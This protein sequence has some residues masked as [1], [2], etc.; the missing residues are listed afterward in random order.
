MIWLTWRQA[1]TQAWVALAALAAV[2]IVLLVTGFQ[3]AHLYDT[4]GV[5]TCTDNC[6]TL[7]NNFQTDFGGS[8]YDPIFNIGVG[9][10]FVVPAIVGIF[11]GAPLIAR[12]LESGTYRLVWNQ[13]VTRTRWL[14]VKLA[15][16]GLAS[17]AFVGLLSLALTWWAAPIDRVGANRLAPHIFAARGVVPL[18]YAAF[19]F[20][21]GVVV[22]MLVRRVVPAMAVTLVVVAAA[23][24]LMPMVVRAH[25]M[26]PVH[27]TVALDIDNLREFSMREGGRMT[28]TGTFQ[29]PGAW[30]LSNETITPSG[31]AFVGPADPQACSRD[32]APQK[33]MDWVVS[34]HLRQYVTYQP[35]SRFW[36]LQFIETGLFLGLAALLT[37]FCFWWVRRR[38]T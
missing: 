16:A 26:P 35:D 33:C 38:L 21:L 31:A 24:I 30:V 36:A 1:R 20:A 37:L 15:T 29:E 11:W 13:S 27:T 32:I 5:A 10:M 25:L 2:A 8:I 9:L 14:A 6:A 17:L 28:V 3:L 18:G 19:A 4:S 34:L 22:G 23:Q 12:E 7:I